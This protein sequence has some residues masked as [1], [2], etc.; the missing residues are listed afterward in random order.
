MLTVARLIADQGTRACTMR[1]YL[2]YHLEFFAG[3]TSEIIKI[4][5]I[6]E[7]QFKLISR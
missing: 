4:F 3:V 7:A 2:E 1:R 6:I 5:R